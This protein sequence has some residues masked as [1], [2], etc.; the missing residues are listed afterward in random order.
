LAHSYYAHRAALYIEHAE[1]IGQQKDIATKSACASVRIDLRPRPALYIPNAQDRPETMGD[2]DPPVQRVSGGLRARGELRAARLFLLLHRVRRA[3]RPDLRQGHRTEHHQRPRPAAR[4]GRPYRPGPARREA[5]RSRRG[6][7][8]GI[9]DRLLRHYA[10]ELLLQARN[11]GGAH[12]ERGGEGLFP[13]Q[14]PRQE[15][16]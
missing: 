5:L 1:A 8:Q 11:L 15:G 12:L 14:A 13:D 7:R 16:L 2:S 9:L 10:G 6:A 4:A 3:F